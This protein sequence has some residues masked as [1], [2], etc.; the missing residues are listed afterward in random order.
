[1]AEPTGFEPAISGLTGQCVK[2][3]YTTAPRSIRPVRGSLISVHDTSKH[4]KNRTEL[5]SR[6]PLRGPDLEGLQRVEETIIETVFV[7]H[8]GRMWMAR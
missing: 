8:V 2:P 1:M 3:G 4:V 6:V 7:G 5:P